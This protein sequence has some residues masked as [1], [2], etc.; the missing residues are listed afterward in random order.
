MVRDGAGIAGIYDMPKNGCW[1]YRLPERYGDLFH[2]KVAL[3]SVRQY[4]ELDLR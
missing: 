2:M 1:R 4:L 3:R